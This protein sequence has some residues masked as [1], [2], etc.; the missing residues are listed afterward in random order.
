MSSL[1][2]LITL[3]ISFWVYTDAKKLGL[4]TANA[5]GWGIGVFLFLIIFLPLYLIKRPAY[6]K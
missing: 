6:K 5:A 1:I 4:P 2:V 3:L